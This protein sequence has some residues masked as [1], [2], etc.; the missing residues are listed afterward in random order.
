MKNLPEYINESIDN[1][2]FEGFLDKLKKAI[3]IVAED[4]QKYFDAAKEQMEELKNNESYHYFAKAK[5]DKEKG[6]E[7]VAKELDD[8]NNDEDL[9]AIYQYV[10]TVLNDSD[11]GYYTRKKGLTGRDFSGV[12]ELFNDIQKEFN[13]N[14]MRAFAIM[15]IGNAMALAYQESKKSQNKSDD[16]YSSSK[17]SS[18]SAKTAATIGCVAAGMMMKR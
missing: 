3:G 12:K 2:I 13:C 5:L 15:Q 4:P 8:L 18:K 16:S 17:S 9:K 11:E 14:P 6:Q 1:Q 10:K 7:L